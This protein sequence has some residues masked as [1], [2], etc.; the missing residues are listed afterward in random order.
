MKGL[1]KHLVAEL[2]NC[3][4]EKLRDEAFLRR[5]VVEGAV[6]SGSH[7]LADFV[8]RFEAGGGGVSA[9]VIIQE[10]HISIHTW[11]EYSYAAVDIF[12]C[13]DSTNPWAALDYVIKELTPRSVNV[14]EIR[15]G[16]LVG[17]EEVGLI[18][19]G[20]TRVEAVEEKDAV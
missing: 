1:G 3:P 17:V 14:M 15:R 16:L 7:I 8:K 13:G 19:Q 18:Q 5:V 11:P 20:V 6:L 12:T 9:V 4:P 2:Y 10:S